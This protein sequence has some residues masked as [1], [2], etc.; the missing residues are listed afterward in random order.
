[1]ASAGVVAA[2]SGVESTEGGGGVGTVIAGIGETS[3][4]RCS[5]FIAVNGLKRSFHWSSEDNYRGLR[6]ISSK[7]KRR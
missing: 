2:P 5:H 1:M 7:V 3:P 6:M 4:R